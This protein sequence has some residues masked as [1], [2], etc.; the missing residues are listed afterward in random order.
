[1]LEEENVHSG[2]RV[3][4]ASLVSNIINPFLMSMVAFVLLA[5]KSRSSVLSAIRW[6]LVMMTIS[7]APILL[8]AVYLVRKGK[9]DGLFTSV[10]QQR[11][12]LYLLAAAVAA[13]DYVVLQFVNAPHLLVAGLGTGLLGLVIFM[14]INFWWKISLH[15]ALATGLALVTGILYGW[16][17]G[18]A[19]VPLVLVGWARVEL[20]EHSITQVVAGALLAAIIG[21]VGFRLFG[22]I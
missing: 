17:A 12:E 11:T 13:V 14:C 7:L 18:A 8:S 2:G 3:R 9:L 20:K 10:R 5:F 6:S 22:V 21:V 15:T 4:L 19:I 1:M 16:I